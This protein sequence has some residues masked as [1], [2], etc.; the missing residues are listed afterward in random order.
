MNR[1]TYVRRYISMLHPQE[2]LLQAQLSESLFS[3]KHEISNVY[4][5][6]TVSVCLSVSQ[7]VISI[8]LG[9]TCMPNN[10][11]GFHSPSQPIT[12]V[13]ICPTNALSLNVRTYPTHKIRIHEDHFLHVRMAHVQTQVTNKATS[14][15]Y[16]QQLERVG[17]A[18][19]SIMTFQKNLLE[20]MKRNL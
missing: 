11:S 20:S 5:R 6:M 16:F 2:L 4:V 12:S 17:T 7:T 18:Y 8:T 15:S 1:A 14:T 10:F 13:G 3:L 19:Q 9:H